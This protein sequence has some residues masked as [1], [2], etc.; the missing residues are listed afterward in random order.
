[1]LLVEEEWYL[2]HVSLAPP[3]HV[4]H[5]P[6]RLRPLGA[7]QLL[8][9]TCARS[10]HLPRVS[11]TYVCHLDRLLMN[12][13]FEGWSRRRRLTSASL[14]WCGAGRG[15]AGRHGKGALTCVLSDAL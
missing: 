2:R 8:M 1:M 9:A 12:N 13:A 5:L 4:P 3:M 6:H 11:S 14:T 10:A 7:L 15:G